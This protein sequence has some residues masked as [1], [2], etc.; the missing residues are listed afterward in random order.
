M[1]R[2]FRVLKFRL[3]ALQEY[4]TLE[5]SK[6]VAQKINVMREIRFH[7]NRQKM[8]CINPINYVFTPHV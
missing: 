8:S 4:N 2:K 6:C 5:V 7:G 3:I 1:L